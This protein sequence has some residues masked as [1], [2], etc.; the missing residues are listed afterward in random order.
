MN[1]IGVNAGSG[2][3]VKPQMSDF[4]SAKGLTRRSQLAAPPPTSLIFSSSQRV[5]AHGDVDGHA[6]C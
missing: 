3:G 2:R 4:F 1:A 6:G 5:T